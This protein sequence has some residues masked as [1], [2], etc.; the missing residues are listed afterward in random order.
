MS[1]VLPTK[2]VLQAELNEAIALSRAWLDH[3][4]ENEA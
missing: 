4:G 2:E 3:H 1:G